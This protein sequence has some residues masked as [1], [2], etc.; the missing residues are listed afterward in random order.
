[1]HFN[2]FF[3]NLLVIVLGI[4]IYTFHGKIMALGLPTIYCDLDFETLV[5][6]LI[7]VLR[8]VNLDELMVT[9]SNL[10]YLQDIV[11]VPNNGYDIDVNNPVSFFEMLFQSQDLSVEQVDGVFLNVIIVNGVIYTVH[12]DFIL[13]LL[14]LFLILEFF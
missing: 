2:K 3:T 12:P 11:G 5:N 14:N 1:M 4:F 6:H 7:N 8:N 9:L 10:E 13:F